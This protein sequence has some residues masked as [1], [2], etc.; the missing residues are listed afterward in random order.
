MPKKPK[1]SLD[2]VKLH[3]TPLYHEG[4]L[5]GFTSEASPEV[6]GTLYLPDGGTM[7]LWQPLTRE[8]QGELE[9]LLERVSARILSAMTAALSPEEAQEPSQDV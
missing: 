1:L 9:A 7:K 2:A 5:T 3:R 8:E 4:Q 6:R